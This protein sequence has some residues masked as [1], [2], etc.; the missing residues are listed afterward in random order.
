[1]SDLLVC[2]G[3]DCYMETPKRRKLCRSC[4]EKEGVL[5]MDLLF[6]TWDREN[7][8]PPRLYEQPREI[9]PHDDSRYSAELAREL[10]QQKERRIKVYR[11]C[12][13]RKLSPFP[14]SHLKISVVEPT[15]PLG[16]G[17]S[18]GTPEP[19]PVATREDF[20]RR[21]G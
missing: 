13:Q 1:M 15:P 18:G 9:L 20:L 12:Y 10:H 16:A 6:P 2:L 4:Q 14:L 3:P 19:V 17:G 21:A 5:W 11:A 8:P 7:P